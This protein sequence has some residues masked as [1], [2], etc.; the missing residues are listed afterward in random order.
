M[1]DLS[2]S[3]AEI[4]GW[5]VAILVVVAM[6]VLVKAGPFH[7]INKAQASAGSPIHVSIVNDP[8]RIGA[9]APAK[10]TA[11]VGQYVIFTNVS[12][13]DHTV[14]A[15]NNA[16]NSLDIGTGGAQWVF[17]PTKPGTFPYVCAYHPLMHGTLVVTP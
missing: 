4:T 9:Y 5:A 16:F 11:R 1:S 8:K 15:E 3:I 7:H 13:A 2:R 6:G 12:N 14:S 10:V 17:K